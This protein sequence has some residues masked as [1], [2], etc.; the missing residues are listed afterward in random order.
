VVAALRTARPVLRD[1]TQLHD[2]QWA[3]H[4][5]PAGAVKDCSVQDFHQLH[6]WVRAHAFAIDIRSCA[7]HFPR[8]FAEFR[9]QIVRA[10]ESIVSNIVEG[11]GAATRKEFARFLDISIKS[12]SEVEYRLQLARDNGLMPG[13]AWKVR[14]DE[15]VEIR[16]ML[17]GLRRAVLSPEQS[18]RDRPGKSR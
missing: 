8:S 15:V 18:P 9:S 3:G 12:A 13:P 16:K 4:A 17:Y 6:V 7:D 11:C 2:R 14:T 1:A 10:A 5:G